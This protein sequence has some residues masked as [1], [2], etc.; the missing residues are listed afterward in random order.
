MTV[1]YEKE[2]EGRRREAW[3]VDYGTAER[4]RK[5]KRK[6]RKKNRKTGVENVRARLAN[7]L[8]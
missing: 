7:T 4:E 1:A 3:L 8:R 6:K 2:A 5:R